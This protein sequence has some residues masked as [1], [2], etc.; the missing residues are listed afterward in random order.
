[1]KGMLE[2]QRYAQQSIQFTFSRKCTCMLL[3]QTCHLFSFVQ[4]HLQVTLNLNGD[5]GEV[6]VIG[7]PVFRL[8]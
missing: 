2:P 5:A 1:M 4:G 6:V 8:L 7:Y 3:L